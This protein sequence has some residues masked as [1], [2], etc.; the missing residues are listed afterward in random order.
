MKQCIAVWAL[1]IVQEHYM[2]GSDP[3]EVSAARLP[4]WFNSCTLAASAQHMVV[5]ITGVYQ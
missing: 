2:R 1:M 5:I 4:G 3:L